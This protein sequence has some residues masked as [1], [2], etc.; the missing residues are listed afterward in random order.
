M[1]IDSYSINQPPPGYI[2]R[3]Q[4]LDVPVELCKDG[5]YCE[6]GAKVDADQ[7]KC[8]AGSFCVKGEVLSVTHDIQW[9]G[10]LQ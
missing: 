8:P 9:K 5:Y 6:A 4:G 7:K 10:K 1:R 2:C 3:T